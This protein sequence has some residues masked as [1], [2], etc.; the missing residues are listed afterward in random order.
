MRKNTINRCFL[1]LWCILFS[2]S[3][4]LV[5]QPTKEITNSI[6]MKLVL[7]PKGRFVMGSANGTEKRHEVIISSDYYLGITEVTVGQYQKLGYSNPSREKY[8]WLVESEAA[9]YPVDCVDWYEA[10]RFCERLSQLPEE[11]KAGRVYRL[12][13]EAEWEYASRAGSP[14]D[15]SSGINW[16]NLNDYAWTK[17]NSGDLWHRIKYK[18]GLKQPNAWGLFDMLGNLEECCSDWYDEYPDGSIT[19]PTGPAEGKKPVH[20]GGNRRVIR[21]GSCRDSF[22]SSTKRDS[23]L[24]FDEFQY[25]NRGFRVAMDM[26]D[27]ID[28]NTMNGFSGSSAPLNSS[29]TELAQ[30]TNSIG[31]KFLQIPSGTFSMGFNGNDFQDG[32]HS[33]HQVTISK[34][35]FLGATEVTQAQYEKV[36]GSNPSQ[37]QHLGIQDEDGTSRPVEQVSWNDAVE[38]CR[39]LSEIPEAGMN[40]H[41]Y[42]LPTEAEWEYACRAGS[43]NFFSFGDGERSLGK[44]GWFINNSERNTHPVG[45]KRPNTWGFYDMHGNVYEWCS[46]WFDKYPISAVIDPV[47]PSYGTKRA[48]RGGCFSNSASDCRASNRFRMPPSFS[49]PNLGFR[50]SM[51]ISKPPQSLELTPNDKH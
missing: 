8:R 4:P 28:E 29:D 38:F 42:R 47:G 12:P 19:D 24:P 13:T 36:M 25:D 33:L 51:T 32:Y 10:E 7:I 27:G 39:R 9:Q 35:F 26:P 20:V 34:D 43:N 6:G 41:I 37:F 44:Y 45:K 46:D 3:T 1:I 18:V 14:S 22:V 48:I 31:M 5:A 2:A 15:L 50:V 40:K 21:G 49:F 30:F 11:I 23:A 17:S 16:Q